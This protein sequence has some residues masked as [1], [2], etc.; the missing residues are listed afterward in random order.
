MSREPDPTWA[1]TRLTLG[2]VLSTALVLLLPVLFSAT[3]EATIAAAGL[4]LALGAL[5]TGVVSLTVVR[6]SGVDSTSRGDDRPLLRSGRV[7]DPTHHPL[8]PRAPGL[9]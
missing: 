7:T 8:R 1:R 5:L 4:A 2:L 3:P 6:R 9:G